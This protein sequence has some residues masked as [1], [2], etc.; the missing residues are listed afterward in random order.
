MMG[1]GLAGGGAWTMICGEVPWGM[2]GAALFL[3]DGSSGAISRRRRR[4][5]ELLG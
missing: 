5:S 1:L 2:A 3:S 4:A